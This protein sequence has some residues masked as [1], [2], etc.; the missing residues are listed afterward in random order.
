MNPA[1]RHRQNVHRRLTHT[2]NVAEFVSDGL[3]VVIC[4]AALPVLVTE[5]SVAI[6]RI[7][8]PGFEF[9]L[10]SLENN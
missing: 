8:G 10:S 4:S 3:K 6:T 7:H 2:E 1:R 9:H 5:Y